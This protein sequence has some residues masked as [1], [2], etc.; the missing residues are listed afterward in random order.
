MMTRTALAWL[1]FATSAIHAQSAADTQPTFEAASIKQHE[2]EDRTAGRVEFLP[3][4][5][6]SATNVP[7]IILIATAWKLPFQGPRF[8]Y[9]LEIMRDRYDVRATASP[10][11]FPPGISTRDRDEK[12]RLMLQSLLT[13]RYRLRM[14]EETR[15]VPV[16]V[17]TVAKGGPRLAKAAIAEKDCSAR[18]MPNGGQPADPSI[19]GG[20]VCHRVWGGA[21]P[22]IQGAAV[23]ISDL[24]LYL[25]GTDD[26]AV[27]DRTGLKGLYTISTERYQQNAAPADVD[28]GLPT[29]SDVLARLGLELK[30]DTAPVEVYRIEHIEK[31]S[32]N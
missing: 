3:G 9:P 11:T 21:G 19:D 26:R 31:P 10:D 4:G 18:T 17:L 29:L 28:A 27:I 25:D 2:A 20:I 12:M 13:E 32:A 30:R 6:F 23:E 15:V 1:L 22:G 16:Y 7:L 14:V 5:R 8:S 24:A